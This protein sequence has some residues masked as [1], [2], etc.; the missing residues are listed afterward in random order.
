MDNAKHQS[1][2][3]KTAIVILN[4]NGEKFLRQF[5][6]NVLQHSN[7]D[8]VK[9]I[10]ADNGSTDGSIALLSEQFPQVGQIRLPQNYGFAEGY[11]RALSQVQATYYVLLNSDV[12]VSP[13]W[14]D[15]LIAF[16]DS[17]P[18]AAA[19]APKLRAFHN[20]QQ[21]EYAGAAGGFIDRWGYPFC[22]GRMLSNIEND[23]AQYDTPMPTFWASGAAMFVRAE[24]YHQAGGLDGR[25]FAHMEEIDLCWR[26]N[27]MGF[28]VWNIPQSTVYHVGGGT[29]PNNTP[30][31][32]YLN[33]RNSLYMLHK[34]LN[35]IALWP[36]LLLRMSLDG[37]S[38]LAY[39]VGAKP[40][41][42]AAVIRAHLDFWRSLGE[43][44][45]TRIQTPKRSRRKIKTI[46]QRSMLIDFFILRRKTFEHLKWNNHN[47]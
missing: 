35:T 32:L 9:V 23:C 15:P 2:D 37:L 47:R 38:G 7:I 17:H 45:R 30:R 41:N 12:E 16:M 33:Y 19:C 8:G 6:P 1:F 22:R 43:A 31:K 34:N 5:L 14:L 46:Y 42:T 13:N 25:F 11:N 29:L 44:K 18:Q 20:H 24:A 40:Q 27:N 3:I 28:Q 39:L 10:V 4:W 26:L 21:F 36:V